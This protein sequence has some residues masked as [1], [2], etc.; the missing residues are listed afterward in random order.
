MKEPIKGKKYFIEAEFIEP[1]KGCCYYHFK[2]TDG[3]P[4]AVEIGNPNI[5]TEEEMKER[6]SSNDG[7]SVACFMSTHGI[8]RLRK[9]GSFEITH[10][11]TAYLNHKVV[12]IIPKIK[13]DSELI[14]EKIGF[15]LSEK[16]IQIIKDL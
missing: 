10:D 15:F 11:Q 13:T 7:E 6:F 4:I 16:D 3:T 14:K 9:G 8:D 12:I 1:T 2:D 5:F